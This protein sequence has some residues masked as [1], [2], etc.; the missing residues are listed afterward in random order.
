MWMI[1]RLRDG[2]V[3]ARESGPLNEGATLVREFATAEEAIAARDEMF[4]PGGHRRA[5]FEA[6]VATESAA[7]TQLHR[8]RSECRERGRLPDDGKPVMTAIGPMSKYRFNMN[9]QVQMGEDAEEREY[10]A[11]HRNWP[12]ARR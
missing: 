6:R 7:A 5:A 2:Y 4:D 9:R 1:E 10:N 3:L 12:P 11:V 8:F